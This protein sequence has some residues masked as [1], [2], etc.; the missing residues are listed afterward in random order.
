ML[1]WKSLN[2]FL[3]ISGISLCWHHKMKSTKNY[4]IT[5]PMIFHEKLYI[6]ILLKILKEFFKG[7]NNWIFILSPVNITYVYFLVNDR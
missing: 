6:D 3:K 5:V 4:T 1:H 7:N 2:C